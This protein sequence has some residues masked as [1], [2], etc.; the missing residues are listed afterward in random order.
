MRRGVAGWI[1]L[2]LPIADGINHF[3]HEQRPP[4]PYAGHLHYRQSDD[5]RQFAKARNHL[6]FVAADFGRWTHG[7]RRLPQA[8]SAAGVILCYGSGNS[9]TAGWLQFQLDHAHNCRHAGGNLYG[10]RQCHV[11]LRNQ[12][13]DCSVHGAIGMLVYYSSQGCQRKPALLSSTGLS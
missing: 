8:P 6:C 2:L 3:K 10:D 9:I 5:H 1:R 13:N 11:R 4:E 12:N 7:R